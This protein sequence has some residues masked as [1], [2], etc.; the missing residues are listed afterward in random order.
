METI[1]IDDIFS[2]DTEEAFFDRVLRVFRY[3]YTYCDLYMQYVDATSSS[4]TSINEL[5][6][7]PFLPIEFFKNHRIISSKEKENIVFRSS[8]TSGM[9]RAEHYV[10]NLAIYEQSFLRGFRYFVG[11]PEDYAIL[12]LLPSYSEKGDSSL[13]YMMQCLMQKAKQPFSKFYL[14]NTDE[15]VD[16]LKQLASIKQK[17][18]LWGVS[19]ALLDF[20]ETHQVYL[21][22]LLVFETG[23]MKGRRKELLREELH[24]RL[25]NGFGVEKIYSEYGMTELL[26]QAYTYGSQRF[27]C[28][29]WMRVQIRD[30]YNPLR[31]LTQKGKSGGVNVIDLANLYSCSFIATQDIGKCY[32]DNSFEIL[33][34]YDNSDIRGCNLLVNE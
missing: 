34:R 9:Q 21:P 33:G 8:G 31:L 30:I 17:T 28:P 24:L 18:I 5:S 27:Y 32:E 16:N 25:R 7:I 12:A 20:I 22:D 15:L 4:V 26:S 13:L 11:Q 3:Q 10:A 29:P 2:I 1:T 19:Y 14:T 23:G 6:Q